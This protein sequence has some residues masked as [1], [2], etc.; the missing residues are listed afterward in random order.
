MP[1]A[2][3]P[4]END[5]PPLVADLRVGHV[6][7]VLAHARANART[8]V[9]GIGRGGRRR[10]RRRLAGDRAARVA[11]P[12]GAAAPVQAART[13]TAEAGSAGHE[14]GDDSWLVVST[15]RGRY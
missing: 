13:A 10:P 3:A 2:P 15:R 7:A 1:S 14:A 8:A 6:D 11:T 9:L 5:I 12:D 4:I